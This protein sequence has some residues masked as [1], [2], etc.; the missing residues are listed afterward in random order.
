MRITQVIQIEKTIVFNFEPNWAVLR[1]VDSGTSPMHDE[2][3]LACKYKVEAHNFIEST[4][5]N[6]SRYY[7]IEISE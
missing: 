7:I 5:L 2:V 3:I 6:S 1:E 4:K